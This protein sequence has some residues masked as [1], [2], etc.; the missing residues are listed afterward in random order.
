ML[1]DL[2]VTGATWPVNP[3]QSVRG[4]R[5]SVSKG[6]TPVLSSAEAT[7]LLAGSSISLEDFIC[8]KIRNEELHVAGIDKMLNNR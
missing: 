1:F 5:H 3:V 6:V 7:A 8:E 2:P 4:P